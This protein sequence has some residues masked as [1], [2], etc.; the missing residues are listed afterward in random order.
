VCKTRCK[1]DALAT[2]AS[3]FWYPENR[4]AG[5]ERLPLGQ[6]IGEVSDDFTDVLGAMIGGGGGEENG[7]LRRSNW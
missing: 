4:E 2:V 3:G 6:Q 7:V 5:S 1:P